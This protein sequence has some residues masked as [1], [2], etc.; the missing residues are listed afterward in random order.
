MTSPSFTTSRDELLESFKRLRPGLSSS[1]SPNVRADVTGTEVRL[2]TEDG[3]VAAIDS[4]GITS[5]TD[6]AIVI[7]AG[8]LQNILKVAGEGPVSVSIDDKGR[9]AVVVEGG[10]YALA[11]EGVDNFRAPQVPTDDQVTVDSA[12]FADAVSQVAPAAAA[13]S[14]RPVLAGVFITHFTEGGS[15]VLRLVATDSLRLAVRDIPGAGKLFGDDGAIVPADALVGAMKVLTGDGKLHV[16]HDEYRVAFADHRTVISMSV[17]AADYPAYER[18]IP[19]GHDGELLV[20]RDDLAA[21]VRRAVA[22]CTDAPTLRV[23]L[24][25]QAEISA[26]QSDVADGES[27]PVGSFTGPKTVFGFNHQ[28]LLDGIS[29]CHAGQ[30]SVRSTDSMSAVTLRNAELDDYT[31]VVMPVRIN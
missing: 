25:G 27:D 1:N 3:D 24:N 23:T 15:D 12:V 29:S 19:T 7:P 21:A 11:T 9:V 13:D 26:H 16:R 31:Y 28:L 18:V 6:G 5:G 14:S 4:F 17:I 10:S 30:L 2:S 20:E 22:A 8:R